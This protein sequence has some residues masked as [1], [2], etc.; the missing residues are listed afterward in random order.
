MHFTNPIAAKTVADTWQGDVA[1]TRAASEKGGERVFV[2]VGHGSVTLILT[3]RKPL[4]WARHCTTSR[5]WRPR[6][7]AST[8]RVTESRRQGRAERPASRP[9]LRRLLRAELPMTMTE[10]KALA[11]VRTVVT[12]E[13]KGASRS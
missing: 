3:P 11:E 10:H 12:S 9:R 1:A 7:T 6:V 8:S 2:T 5:G 13:R 4:T